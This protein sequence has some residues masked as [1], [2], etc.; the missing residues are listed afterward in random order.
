[1]SIKIECATAKEN[2]TQVTLTLSARV[3]KDGKDIG[4]VYIN[5][6]IPLSSHNTLKEFYRPVVIQL[7][8]NINTKYHEFIRTHP[9]IKT[10]LISLK[11]EL[12]NEFRCAKENTLDM[13]VEKVREQV[14]AKPKST[15]DVINLDLAVYQF[16]EIFQDVVCAEE[17][18]RRLY[19]NS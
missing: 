16:G 3:I 1:M 14:V 9:H 13:I 11:E 7:P 19:F 2:G 8:V 18:Y 5:D 4:V 17:F 15:L 6:N 12:R 10:S